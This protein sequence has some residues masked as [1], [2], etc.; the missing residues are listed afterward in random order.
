[1][2]TAAVGAGPP[3][4]QIPVAVRESVLDAAAVLQLRRREISSTLARA[5]SCDAEIVARGAESIHRWMAQSVYGWRELLS[6][7]PRST[8]AE[9]GVSLPTNRVVLERGLRMVS[10]FGRDG[11]DAGSR[12][13]LAGERD[14]R[15]LFGFTPVQMKIVDRRFV[16]LQGPF[17]G[18]GPTLVA[19]RSQP[20]MNAAWHYWHAVVGSAYPAAEGTY[21][22]DGL[23]AR[24]RQV[25]ALLT[26][27]ARDEAI[28]E[29]LGVSVR[30]VR[31]DIAAIMAALGVRTRFAAGLRLRQ[32]KSPTG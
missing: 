27:D 32:E 4:E 16:L 9:L 13:L 21:D 1:M 11:S 2:L 23:S 18:E 26:A 22:P 10:I 17:L 28:A 15:Y 3:P 8:A 14:P 25:V 5:G 6:V 20:C 7:R 12:S 29:A 31:Y 19:A 30:T 24:Q